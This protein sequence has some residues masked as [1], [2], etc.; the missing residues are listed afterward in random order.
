MPQ[1]ILFA[2]KFIIGA[3]LLTWAL[4]LVSFDGVL[5]ALSDLTL[6]DIGA[7]VGLFI[8]AHGT[9]ALKL[10][11]LLPQLSRPQA[12]RF[13]MIAVLYATALPGQ[14]AGDAVKAFRLTR[15]SSRAGNVSAIIAAVAVDKAT[16]LFALLLLTGLGLGLS[17]QAFGD[18]I[19]TFVGLG[20]S[21]I[22]LL[23][24][25]LLI[26]PT[27][28]FIKKSIA[29]FDAWRQVSLS[30]GALFQSLSMGILYQAVSIAIFAILGASLGLDLSMASWAVVVGLVSIILLLPVT[31]AGVGLRETSLVA[32]MTALGQSGSAALALSLVLLLFNVLGAVVG[33]F[34]DLA[35]SDKNT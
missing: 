6:V 8:I 31:I 11:I 23:F 22:V 33:L 19:A 1:P 26:V 14:L 3:A 34:A 7:V 30:T 10:R 12:L 5:A 25:V 13:T 2:S 24:F 28:Q 9:N 21:L 32:I 18:E 17:I 4:S 35:G 29:N 15:A 27:P 16:G 20:L